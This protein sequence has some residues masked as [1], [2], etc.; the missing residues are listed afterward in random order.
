MHWGLKHLLCSSHDVLQI[1]HD[2]IF[3]IFIRVKIEKN[4]QKN[5]QLDSLTYVSILFWRSLISTSSPS[6]YIIFI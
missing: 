5:H 1:V 2:D 6:L 4:F 3:C